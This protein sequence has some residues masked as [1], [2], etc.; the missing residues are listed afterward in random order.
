MSHGYFPASCHRPLLLVS[1]ILLLG[2][3]G[4]RR[5]QAAEESQP[6]PSLIERLQ[7]AGREKRESASL[8]DLE[9]AQELVAGSKLEDVDPAG[10]TALHWCVLSAQSYSTPRL[11]DAFLRMSEEL[12]NAGC[13]ANAQDSYGN[14]PLDYQRNPATHEL[15]QFLID[16]GGQYGYVAKCLG[17]GLNPGAAGKR[18]DNVRIRGYLQES[19]H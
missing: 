12:L 7:Q 18:Q 6:A 8:R 3:P 14:T 10:R 16:Q 2:V 17:K 9:A 15:E 19:F 4:A 11:K 5:L 1:F 13:D